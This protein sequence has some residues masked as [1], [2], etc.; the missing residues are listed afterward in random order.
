MENIM[1]LTAGKK[2]AIKKT[3]FRAKDI[4]DML[5][6]KGQRYSYILAQSGIQPEGREVVG[7]GSYHKFSLKNAVQF[8]I[9]H[10][11]SGM[12]LPPAVM[13]FILDHINKVDEEN[14]IG[15]YDPKVLDI[16]YR[17][18]IWSD[19][20]SQ[21]P[22]PP[23]FYF[24]GKHPE[25]IVK[26]LKEEIKPYEDVHGDGTEPFEDIFNEG[27]LI[28]PPT[29]E[30]YFENELNR[31]IWDLEMKMTYLGEPIE[32]ELREMLPGQF[33]QEVY[34]LEPMDVE[35]RETFMVLNLKEIRSRVFSYAS[36]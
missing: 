32:G 30:E 16:E 36:R 27:K 33:H 13:K 5:K 15:I 23:P 10:R 14:G 2:R 25:H 29:P 1:P 34:E 8:R 22:G 19:M 12:G 26:K 21:M 31:K 24:S 17:L 3:E 4:K 18:N 9:A 20:P 7:R 11:L 28:Y 35:E 6:I